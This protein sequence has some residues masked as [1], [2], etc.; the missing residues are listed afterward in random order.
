[1]PTKFKPTINQQKALDAQHSDILVSAS[2]G[3]GKTRILVDR[4]IQRLLA[5]QSIDHYLIV[6]FT[7]AAAREMKVRLTQT[8]RQQLPK[9]AYASI[10]HIS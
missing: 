2:A 5:G 4:I 1:M 9:I 3:S 10:Y 6:T 7:E 8:I